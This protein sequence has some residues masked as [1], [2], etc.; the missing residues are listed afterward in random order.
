MSARAARRARSLWMSEA[1][2]VGITCAANLEL[3]EGLCAGA[4]IRYAY[5]RFLR[6]SVASE[7]SIARPGGACPSDSSETAAPKHSPPHS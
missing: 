4:T 6:K 5:E 1:I 7:S 2:G 3:E